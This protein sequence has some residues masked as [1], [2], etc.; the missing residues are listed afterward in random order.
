MKKIVKLEMKRAFHSLGFFIGL[1]V[2]A[3]IVLLHLMTEII[4]VN[5]NYNVTAAGMNLKPQTVWYAWLGL[6]N[7][8]THGYN[9]IYYTLVPI[10]AALP[11]AASAW[12][13]IKTGYHLQICTR[14][15]QRAYYAA[16]YLSVFIS[17][18]VVCAMPLILDL[19]VCHLFLPDFIPLASDSMKPVYFFP[20]S[21]LFYRCPMAYAI[22]F[23]GI[24]FAF[25]GVYACL[26]LAAT[27]FLKNRF[28]IQIFPYIFQILI[29]Y[30]ITFVPL[31][32][33][34]LVFYSEK[35]NPAISGSYTWMHYVLQFIIY[36]AITI[37]FWMRGGKKRE[38]YH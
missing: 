18:G 17:G 9:Y 19:L 21:D 32:E 3:I 35:I 28:L 6:Y 8:G 25:G 5:V 26:G 7:G 14:I 2:G 10:L 27:E 12:E 24:L 22:F 31:E 36:F 37:F 34:R 1:A 23:T 16:K 4:P 38:L 33:I 20:W 11:Y 30:L 15:G 13:D 29:S